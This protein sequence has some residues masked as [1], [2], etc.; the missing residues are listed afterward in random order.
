[1]ANPPNNNEIPQTSVGATVNMTVSEATNVGSIP[2]V[3][4]TNTGPI[5]SL[6]G[7]R[8]PLGTPP[9][10]G[11]LGTRPVVPPGFIP[12]YGM[13]TSEVASL[14]NAASTFSDPF[15]SASSP[16]QGSGVGMANRNRTQ[17]VGGTS[18]VAHGL[19]N[20]STAVLRQ[21]MDESNHDMV[22]M[23]AQT[24][25]PKGANKGKSGDICRG[26]NHH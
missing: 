15:V 25:T 21:Q 24:L 6:T 8:I 12:F 4:V 22:Q 7:P 9:P 19:T 1:M 20:A 26:R 18:Q 10:R 17:L 23:L 5:T 13:P 14:T 3:S 2:A 16:L 11:N